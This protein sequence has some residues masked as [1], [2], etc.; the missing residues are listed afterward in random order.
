M[1]DVA[2]GSLGPDSRL[3]ECIPTPGD[4]LLMAR[5][6]DV[7]DVRTAADA[8]I[9]TSEGSTE[10][11]SIEQRVPVTWTRC[12]LGGVRPWFRCS[13]SVGGRPCGRRVAKL[14]LRDAPVFAY[15]HCC[16]LAYASQQE[17]PRHR[18]ISRAQKLRM[19]LGGSANLLKPFPE[20]PRGMHRTTYYRLSAKA[21]EAQERSIAL[22]VDHLH[23]LSRPS[24]RLLSSTFENR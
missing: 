13:A 18:A 6:A 23:R 16:G 21:M 15:R 1:R 22:A 11:K 3:P 9:L 20:R 2:R 4:P 5:R 10:R 19:R 24:P 14:Y 17:V 7:F 12:H 8:L